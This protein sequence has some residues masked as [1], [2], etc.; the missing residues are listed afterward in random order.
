MEFNLLIFK[1]QL[2]PVK[3]SIGQMNRFGA[4]LAILEQTTIPGTGTDEP[5]TILTIKL[6]SGNIEDVF[7]LGW[8]AAKEPGQ[9]TLL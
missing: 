9:I 2:E 5:D 3:Y 6:L 4:K 8:K 7:H 1:N